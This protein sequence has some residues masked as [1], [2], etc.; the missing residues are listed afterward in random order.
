V[1]E[2]FPEKERALASGLFNSGSAVGA[3]LAPP[4]V[5]YL[6]LHYGW[7]TA[8]AFVG[9]AGLLWLVFWG[10]M[11]FTP[12]ATV[13]TPKLAP[14]PVRELLSSR[15]LWAFTFSKIFFDSVW[16]FYIFWFPEYLKR[17]RHFDLA[18]IGKVAWIP[19]MVA[20]FGNLLGGLLSGYLLR[21]GWSVTAARKS[22]V[23]F[24]CVLM[25]SAIPAVLAGEAWLSIAFV[26][27]AMLG[28]TGGLANM[29]TI[30]SDVYSR[31][32][33]ASVY[34]LASMGSGFGG[35]LFT[36]ITGWVVDHYSYTPVFIGFG[37][38]PLV[39]ASILWAFAGPLTPVSEGKAQ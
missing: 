31:N 17:V 30:P 20:G 4:V 2:W 36:L 1:A 27:V 16:Y 10:R 8:F 19:F 21:R 38:V 14:V 3:I 11:Y 18:G 28:Y 32:A 9:L 23:T 15:F 33:V 7:R 29:L 39:C 22:A 37:F 13:E 35:M 12:E 26:S 34:G 24:F 5:A 6:M 25:M